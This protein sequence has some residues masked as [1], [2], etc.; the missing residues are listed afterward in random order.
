MKAAI[1]S[2]AITLYLAQLSYCFFTPSSKF[3]R[4]NCPA[5]KCG[6]IR[7]GMLQRGKKMKISNP[8][9]ETKDK[10]QED[11]IGDDETKGKNQTSAQKKLQEMKVKKEALKKEAKTEQRSEMAANVDVRAVVGP[12]PAFMLGFIVFQFFVVLV[13]KGFN[14]RKAIATELDWE[15]LVTEKE[16]IKE[17]HAY[18]CEKCGYCLFPARSRHKKFFEDVA[19]YK[20]PECGAGK[21]D[22]V[23][24]HD[25][26]NPSN[27]HLSRE[28]LQ[29]SLEEKIKNEAE[30]LARDSDVIIKPSK[31][32]KK[33]IA[34][35]ETKKDVTKDEE[36][37]TE[38][39]KDDEAKENPSKDVEAKEKPSKADE[40]NEKSSKADEANEKPKVSDETKNEV[41]MADERSESEIKASDEEALNNENKASDDVPKK[42]N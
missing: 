12:I 3:T 15:Y 28:E 36:E 21:E 19:D 17:L 39:S 20:C 33:K 35:N 32:T 24:I 16:H 22:F 42:E 4:S 10:F 34:E 25:L 37:K 5:R 27:I 23:D 29:A 13:K 38:I 40:T 18:R 14:I 6:S 31:A 1:L 7:M 41:K 26:T 30:A 11:Y 2:C 8:H 9:S